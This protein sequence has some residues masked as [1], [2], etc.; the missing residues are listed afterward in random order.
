VSIESAAC[1]TQARI[2]EAESTEASPSS[3]GHARY[4]S[5]CIGS[6]GLDAH[7]THEQVV[8][9]TA[10]VIE[11]APPFMVVPEVLSGFTEDKA[12]NR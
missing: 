3:T 8:S 2:F 12:P 9:D 10:D 1:L 4:A 6:G 7:A 5:D 11:S